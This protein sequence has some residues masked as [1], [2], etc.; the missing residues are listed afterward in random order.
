[1]ALRRLPVQF[2]LAPPDLDAVQQY[3]IILHKTKQGKNPASTAG[4]A[5]STKQC[6]TGVSYKKGLGDNHKSRI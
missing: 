1:M 4:A 6:L 3:K 2:R 5:I